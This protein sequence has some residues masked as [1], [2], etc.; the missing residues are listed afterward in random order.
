M[1]RILFIFAACVV[2][3]GC[4]SQYG[5]CG[6]RVPPPGTGSYGTPNTYYPP[7]GRTSPVI[8]RAAGAPIG[9]WHNVSDSNATE[10]ATSSGEPSSAPVPTSRNAPR[11]LST[12][13]AAGKA[14]V[15]TTKSSLSRLN[16]MP[17]NEVKPAV[18]P[19]SFQSPVTPAEA[20]RNAVPAA[21]N[22]TGTPPSTS[23]PSNS[24]RGKS[25]AMGGSWQSRSAPDA[26]RFAGG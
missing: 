17:V 14:S 1:L 7:A 9:Q 15:P 11:V 26:N 10:L 21:E 24:L 13:A 2:P 23:S 5:N 25:A 3:I 18:A 12:S 8:P 20:N 22:A 6:T 19:A 4:R 16:G